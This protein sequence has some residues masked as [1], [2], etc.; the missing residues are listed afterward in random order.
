[1]INQLGERPRARSFCH[2]RRTISRS[3]AQW[4]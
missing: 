1:M 3:K 2:S 4:L